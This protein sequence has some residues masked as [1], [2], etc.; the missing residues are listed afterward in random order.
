MPAQ[1]SGDGEPSSKKMRRI[2]ARAVSLLDLSG[3]H[4]T[5][6]DVMALV[7]SFTVVPHTVVLRDNGLGNEA[8]KVLANKIVR[9]G[10]VLDVGVN[11]IG[12]EG[13]EA[14]A[15]ALAAK[16]AK[17]RTL[18]IDSNHVGEAAVVFAEA[19]KSAGCPIEHLDLGDNNVGDIGASAVASALQTNSRLRTLGLSCNGVQFGGAR[20]IAEALKDN[21]TLVALHLNSNDHIG[22]EGVKLLASVLKKNAALAVVNLSHVKMTAEGLA[23]LAEALKQN[24]SLTVLHMMDNQLDEEAANHLAKSLLVNKT[25]SHVSGVTSKALTELLKRNA[26]RQEALTTL[27]REGNVEAMRVMVEEG[28]GREVSQLSGLTV[29]HVCLDLGR[30]DMLDLLLRGRREVGQGFFD[31]NGLAR[32]R[33]AANVEIRYFVEERMIAFFCCWGRKSECEYLAAVPRVIMRLIARFAFE[34]WSVLYA[35]NDAI[36]CSPLVASGRYT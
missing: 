31:T 4:L 6:E 18:R 17:L 32:G 7:E 21:S 5:D 3:Q 1:N 15:K 20:A 29:Y 11:H 14:L 25:L 35:C 10:H 12:Q 30:S 24:R 26:E 13:A 34:S 28:V 27:A 19:L 9:G 36:I 23:A 16:E 8:A 2:H 33:E 22:D